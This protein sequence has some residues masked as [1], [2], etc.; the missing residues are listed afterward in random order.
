MKASET[1]E[2]AASL[3][4]GD[5]KEKHGDMFHSHNLI[6]KFWTAYLGST[7]N[8]HDVACLMILLKVARTKC[9]EINPDDYIDMAGYAAIAGELVERLGRP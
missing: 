1:L 3:I 6:A 8:A 4:S 2:T 9:G 7:I 5:R